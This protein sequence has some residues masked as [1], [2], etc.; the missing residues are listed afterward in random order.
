MEKYQLY[1]DD[2][3]V[4]LKNMKND[5]VMVDSVVCDPPYH[6]TS[7]V[8]RFKN[9]SI[10]DDNSTGEKSKNRD[11]ALSRLSRGFMGQTWDGGDLAF[12]PATWKLVYDVMKPGAHLLTFGGTRTFHR[13]I[14]AIEDAGFEIRDCLMWMYGTG[15]PKSHNLDGNFEG[16]GTALKPAWEPI[17]FARK[18]FNGTVAN[19]MAMYGTGAINVDKCRIEIN[20][21]IDDPRLGGKGSW[22]TDKAAKMVYEGGYKGDNISS[23]NLGRWPANVIHDGSDEVEDA[24]AEF[25]ERKSGSLS[26]EQQSKGGWS[27][28]AAYGAGSERGGT[29]E[30][31]GSTGSASRFFYSAKASAKDRVYTCKICDESLF[32]SEF[33][34]HKHNEENFNHI[35]SHPT[36]KPI[37]L[38]K[39]LV[40][41]V[42]PTNGLVLDPFSGSGTTLQAAV[43]EGFSCIG[44]EKELGYYKNIEYRMKNTNIPSATKTLFD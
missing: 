11:N 3:L 26:A 43:E 22:K 8:S 4:V 37:S 9:T 27:H 42:T 24:F 35:T 23:S 44:I 30:Y 10:D 28:H 20:P 41:L 19:N 25:G 1:N 21:E 34:N 13:M 33:K 29:N 14:C 2:C 6:L 38:M 12:D 39:Y 36:C 31:V 15:F 7:I 5:G 32:K 16:W 17:V 40:K 18:P